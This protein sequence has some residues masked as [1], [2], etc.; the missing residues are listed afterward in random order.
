MNTQLKPQDILILLK[1]V[2]LRGQAWT[3]AE[4]S[5]ALCMSVSEV[6]QGIKRA[7]IAHLLRIQN[8]QKVPIQEALLEFLIHGV[9]YAFPAERGSFVRGIPTAHAVPPLQN[10]L[11]ASD[12]PPPVWAHPQGRVKGYKLTPLYKSVPDAALQDIELYELL[13]L[14]DALRDGR[15]REKALA[16]ELLQ[17]RLCP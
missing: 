17:T 14:V 16:T 3:F 1:L 15:A 13:A 5:K 9:K 11:I 4:L 7:H 8:E 6:H 10:L 12:E 2:R